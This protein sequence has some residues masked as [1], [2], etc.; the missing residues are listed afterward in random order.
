MSLL[1]VVVVFSMFALQVEGDLEVPHI[2]APPVQEVGLASED[3][4]AWAPVVDNLADTLDPYVVLS[5]IHVE[6]TGNPNA[7]R[8]GSRYYG[9]LQ[10]SDLYIH[11]AL[12]FAGIPRQPASSLMGDGQKSIRVFV[13]Y[14]ER[15]EF[16]HGWEPEK[17]ATLHKVGPTAFQRIQ[18]RMDKEGITFQASVCRDSTP[19]VCRY[20][21]RY[22]RYSA[23]Y[24]DLAYSS[25]NSS[26]CLAKWRE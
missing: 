6:S 8:F 22:R 17:V 14:M 18:R 16:L 10:I 11:D 2:E 25:L 20:L 15:Y 1:E 21:N 23:L 13:W 19:N 3:V 7:R 4:K 12:D 9:L 24:K 26:F 5:L